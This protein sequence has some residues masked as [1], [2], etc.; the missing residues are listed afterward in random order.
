MGNRIVIGLLSHMLEDVNLGCV[1]LSISNIK[2]IEEV[3]NKEKLEARYVLFVNEKMQQPQIDFIHNE[4]EY[5]IYSS[6][7]KTLKHPIQWITSKIFNDCDIVFNICAGDGFT[8]IYG[9]RRIFSETYMSWLAKMNKCKIVLAPQTI[10]P[11]ENIL[12]CWIAKRTLKYIDLIFARDVMSINCCESMGAKE[13]TIEVIDVAF[14]LPYQ[15]QIVQ[16]NKIGINVSGLLYR[17]GYNGNNYFGL[18]FDYQ[19]YTKK[20]IKVLLS[21]GFFVNLIAHVI[22]DTNLVEDDFSACNEIANEIKGVCVAPKFNSPIEAKSYISGMDFFIGARMHSTI[23][24]FSSGVPVVPIAYSRKVNG[25]YNSLEYPYYID[26]KASYSVE[27][28]IERTVQYI[29]R[30]SMLKE[31]LEISK[32]IYEK[33]LDDYR[34]HIKNVF[35]EIEEK[36]GV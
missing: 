33:K 15:K 4:Y 11:F 27:S 9:I 32:R 6:C 3:L 22:S 18:S 1:A 17:G 34:M 21:Q 13:K 26:A 12:S 2:I 36:N 19:L 24:A 25:L 28:A 5:R 8:S 35:I 20:L 23:A 31:Q 30:R 16:K 14:A 7:K 10:G 29:D